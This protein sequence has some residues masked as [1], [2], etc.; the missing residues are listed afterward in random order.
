MESGQISAANPANELHGSKNIGVTLFRGEGAVTVLPVSSCHENI[1]CYLN[2][3]L[4]ITA[5]LTGYATGWFSGWNLDFF[6]RLHRDLLFRNL[7]P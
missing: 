4:S 5:L 6:H 1:F 7:N 2:K 3:I